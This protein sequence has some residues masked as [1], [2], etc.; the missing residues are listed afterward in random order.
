MDPTCVLCV[1]CFKQSPHRHHKY[2][3]STSNGGG[4][5]DCGDNEAWKSD[6]YC[7]E[8]IV[9]GFVLIFVL[10][11][12]YFYLFIF[13]YTFFLVGNRKTKGKFYHHRTY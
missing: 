10:F 4:C 13:F 6:P 9:S 7:N 11:C 12:L 8:H 1:T 5:C 3:M 2:K